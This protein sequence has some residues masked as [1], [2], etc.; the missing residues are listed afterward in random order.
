M[1]DHFY[2]MKLIKLGPLTAT[3]LSVTLINKS[4]NPWV[5]V[6]LSPKWVV[7]QSKDTTAKRRE[8][9]LPIMQKIASNN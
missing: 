5:L 2:R 1:R 7:L 8:P 6:N 3:N 4:N 9:I